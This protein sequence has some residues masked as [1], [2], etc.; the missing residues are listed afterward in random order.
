MKAANDFIQG[1]SMLQFIAEEISPERQAD[2]ETVFVKEMG[3]EPTNA[4]MVQTYIANLDEF[5]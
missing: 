1:R 4:E 5:D 2:I 3:R